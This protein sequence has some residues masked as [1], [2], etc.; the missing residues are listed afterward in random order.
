MRRSISLLGAVMVIL[1]GVGCGPATPA[2]EDEL[3]GQYQDPIASPIL[4]G[5]GC[6]MPTTCGPDFERCSEWTALADCGAA[7]AC[8]AFQYRSCYDARGTQCLHVALSP[9]LS[10]ACASR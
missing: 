6:P 1:V 2:D 7:S 4:M 10:G 9:S 8:T 5:A 3:V